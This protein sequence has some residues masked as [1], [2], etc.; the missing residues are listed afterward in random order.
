MNALAEPMAKKHWPKERKKLANRLK[1]LRDS[2]GWSNVEL[3]D[4]LGITQRALASYLYDISEV[5]GCILKL[6]EHGEQGRL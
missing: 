5:P 4:F 3:A 6:L 1:A 2:R